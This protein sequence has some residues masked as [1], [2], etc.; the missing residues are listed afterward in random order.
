MA[1]FC[2]NEMN[3]VWKKKRTKLSLKGDSNEETYWN[4]KYQI[5]DPIFS[6]IYELNIVNAETS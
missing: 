1:K 3:P 6:H 2:E 5:L 4:F